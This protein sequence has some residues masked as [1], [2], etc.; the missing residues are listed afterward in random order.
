MKRQKIKSRKQENQKIKKLILLLVVILL[1]VI[2]G[3]FFLLKGDNKKIQENET[4]GTMLIETSYCNLH[5]PIEYSDKITAKVKDKK[6]E[7]IAIEDESDL[8]TLYF[9]EE[10]E[11]L[12]GTVIKD[13]QS[14]ALYAEFAKLDNKHENYELH[15]EYQESVNIIIE[16]LKK[17]YEFVEGV[18]VEVDNVETFDIETDVV[19]LKYPKK[20]KEKVTI[21]VGE[22][23][24]SF[25][26]KDTPI[27]DICF[28]EGYGSCFG[29][30]ED[31]PVCIVSYAIDEEAHSE[32][33]Y[34]MMCEMQ[35]DINVI[36][37]NLMQEKGF[38]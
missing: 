30:Y 17:E 35:E 5:L 21:E 25:T 22:T 24:V 37:N 38:N 27:F 14:I 8:F 33:E 26:M 10:A 12:L 4:S 6:V 19:T 7:F 20:W 16:N 3:L 31:T 34:L 2:G 36:L 15:C 9:N 23:K 32:E 28:E 29:F 1:V 11:N 13:S 18:I